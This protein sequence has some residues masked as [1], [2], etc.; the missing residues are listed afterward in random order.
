MLYMANNNNT[1]TV[2]ALNVSFSAY[3]ASNVK[4]D[5]GKFYLYFIK[6]GETAYYFKTVSSSTV[7]DHSKTKA[8][9]IVGTSNHGD[10]SDTTVITHSVEGGAVTVNVANNASKELYIN[11]IILYKN[12][13][14]ECVAVNGQ[15]IQGVS[16]LS[17]DS[18]RFDPP[19]TGYF[20]S[21]EYATYEI[22]TS[23]LHMTK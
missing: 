15:S 4:T 18:V 6:P 5:W 10:A 2:N 8:T 19:Y 14:G 23:A 3:T 16:A 21:I 9:K 1:T 17:S 13:A 11:V 20:N 7:I 22:W 12:A